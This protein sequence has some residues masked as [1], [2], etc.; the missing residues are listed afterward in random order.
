MNGHFSARGIAPSIA[1][2]HNNLAPVF[3][4]ISNAALPHW[5]CSRTHHWK[6]RKKKTSPAHGR[7]QTHDFDFEA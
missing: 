3:R 6:G 7:I 4:E 1:P 2:R 5:G